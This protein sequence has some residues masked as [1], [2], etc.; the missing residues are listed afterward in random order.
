MLVAAVGAGD[1]AGQAVAGD[2]GDRASA[3]GRRRPRRGSRARPASGPARRS[4]SCPPCSRRTEASASAI[5][6]EPPA[7]TGQPTLWQA[8]VSAIPTEALSGCVSGLKEWAATPANRARVAGV[9]QRRASS[10]AGAAAGHAE[11]GQPQRVPG[12]VQDR[13]Q[14]VLV[15]RVEVRGRRGEQPPPGLA[16]LAEPRRGLLERADHRRGA[17][18]VER[19]GEVDLG[20]APLEPVLLQPERAEE[21]RGR[22]HRVPR[23]ADVV[24]HARQRSVRRCGCRRRSSPPPPAPSPRPRPGPAPPRRPARWGRSR[25]PSPCSCDRRGRA[26]LAGGR[27]C[28]T[29][30]GNSNDSSSQGWRSTMS[31]TATEPSSTSPVA[32]S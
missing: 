6:C 12:Q 23:R 22:R 28:V 21:G 30:T 13:A 27:R 31:A 11:A 14:Q 8:A 17:A 20:P 5:D 15:E 4:R 16:V 3:R 2:L 18:V 1:P 10:V 26:L 32:A 9:F 7:A 29:S 25:R 24:D 19:V